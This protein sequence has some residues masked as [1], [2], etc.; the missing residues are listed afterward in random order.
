MAPRVSNALYGLCVCH[1]AVYSRCAPVSLRKEDD[2]RSPVVHPTGGSLRVFTQLS[3]LGV[4]SVKV[5]SSRPTPPDRACRDHQ[6]PEG[7]YPA[8]LRLGGASQTPAVGQL[9]IRLLIK[10][11]IMSKKSNPSKSKKKSNDDRQ[12]NSSSLPGWPG[13]RTRQGRSGYDPIDSR[14]EAGHMA[15]T[16]LQKLFTGQIRNRIVLFL[17]SVLGLILITPL[18]VVISE[19]W[20]GNLFPWNAWLFALVIAIVGTAILVNVIRNLLRI[21]RGQ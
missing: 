15:G 17:L 6:Y 13:Y 2:L 5:A 9:T 10:E 8:R 18:V 4:G 19:A 11:F 14:A 3:W 1:F 7:A 12:D 20:N 21:I 16:I